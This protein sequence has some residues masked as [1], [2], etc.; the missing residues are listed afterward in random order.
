ME[1]H[2]KGD[3]PVFKG[4]NK[5]LV[6]VIASVLGSWDD[7]KRIADLMVQCEEAGFIKRYTGKSPKKRSYEST[8]HAQK[9][10]EGKDALLDVAT[11]EE[12]RVAFASDPC[13]EE[14]R[15][16]FYQFFEEAPSAVAEQ[17]EEPVSKKRGRK[18]QVTESS[19]ELEANEGSTNGKRG[20]GDDDDNDY[21]DNDDD[22]NDDDDFV[23]KGSDKPGRASRGRSRARAVA[24]EL[25]E[26]AGRGRPPKSRR[27]S[28]RAKQH[29]Q[30][31]EVGVVYDAALS[32]SSPDYS[33]VIHPVIVLEF[34]A[35]NDLYHCQLLAFWEDSTDWY[36][37][38]QLHTMRGAGQ[39][40]WKAGDHVQ[41]RIRRRTVDGNAVDGNLG[42]AGV[43]VKGQI[44]NRTKKGY[45]VQH[46]SWVNENPAYASVG[47]EDVRDDW[48]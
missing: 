39:G 13:P 48:D 22:D 2:G 16:L 3:P 33:D 30:Q 45:K 20:R 43:W 46:V 38:S 17:N 37:P 28:P 31:F 36:V 5:L 32:G 14:L 34:D 15:T 27:A 8:V 7:V 44:V 10:R 35:R 47:P 23:E 19:A 1:K 24:L 41:I 42:D 40:P 12:H 21:N 29:K 26:A 18:K 9:S 25:D 6:K 11:L 4:T